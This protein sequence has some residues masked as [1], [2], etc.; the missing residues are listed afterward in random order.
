LTKPHDDRSVDGGDV[1]A[2]AKAPQAG[3]DTARAAPTSASSGPASKERGPLGELLRG[4]AWLVGIRGALVVL[5]GLVAGSPLASSVLGA[6]LTDLG[7]GRAGAGWDRDGDVER[8][9]AIGRFLRG[10]SLG[11]SL[12][13]LSLL[14]AH[15]AGWATLRVVMPD[16]MLLLALLA[17]LG[18]AMRHELLYRVLPLYVADRAGV[19]SKLAIPFAASLGVAAASLDPQSTLAGL[20]LE[21]GTGLLYASLAHHLRGAWAPI[22]AHTIFTF[23]VGAASRGGLFDVRYLSGELTDGAS[24]SGAPAYVA[25]FAAALAALALVPRIAAPERPAPG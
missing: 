9:V 15:V 2:P 4:A 17:A 8:R 3:P 7:V 23:L 10:A 11:A 25:A 14:T 22:A 12:A 13:A 20:S 18:T 19:P 21:L 5:D 1:E 6:L 16:P 24:S